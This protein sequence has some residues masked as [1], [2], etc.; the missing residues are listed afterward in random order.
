M[1]ERSAALRN[2]A[3]TCAFYTLS[4]AGMSVFNKM[5]IMALPLPITLVMVQMV[6]GPRGAAPPSAPAPS[7][8]AVSLSRWQVFTVATICANWRSVQ[9]GS[10][11]DALRWGCTVPLLF[12]A[13]LVSSMFAMEHNTLGTVVVFRNVAPLFTLLIERLFRVPM[14]ARD[15]DPDP[16]PDPDTQ[17]DPGPDSD[18]D[19]DP[20]PGR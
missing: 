6:R 1:A 19:P 15:P 11:R 20:D 10:R 3:L 2:M 14:Q 4:S 17:L 7:V 16:D 18:P 12:S 8:S 13:M 5:A 9:I